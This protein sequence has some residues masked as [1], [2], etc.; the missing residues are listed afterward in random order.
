MPSLPAPPFLRATTVGAVIGIVLLLVGCSTTRAPE[1]VA[2]DHEKVVGMW[3]YRTEGTGVL[4]RGT[5]RIFVEEG[6][7]KGLLQDSWRGE[8]DALVQIQG[9]RMELELDRV[10]ISGRLRENRFEGVVQQRKWAVTTQ[11]TPRSSPGR[12]IARRVQKPSAAAAEEFGC[13][14]LLRESSYICSPFRAP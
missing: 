1:E 5:L 10:R 12:L 14:S 7:L 4:Q 2:A 3:E 11:G 6:R 13:P 8:I 9:A